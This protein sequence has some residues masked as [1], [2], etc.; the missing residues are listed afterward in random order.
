MIDQL[1]HRSC[2]RKVPVFQTLYTYYIMV[3][4]SG[5][6][7]IVASCCFITK[8][9]LFLDFNRVI[10]RI[11]NKCNLAQ[12]LLTWFIQIFCL[13]YPFPG[14][15]VVLMLFAR[16]IHIFWRGCFPDIST[17]SDLV[18]LSRYILI[19]CLCTSLINFVHL[20]TH[21]VVQWWTRV[22]SALNIPIGL[23]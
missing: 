12:M 22:A 4:F 14:N 17:S 19:F 8:Y 21:L 10:F 16:F 9:P 1:S 11:R 2:S 23:S 18:L 15:S 6:I 3:R 5:S 7:W 20:M 13:N